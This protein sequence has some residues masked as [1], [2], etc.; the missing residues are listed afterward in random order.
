MVLNQTLKN[1]ALQAGGSHYP[2]V[3]T[4]QLLKFAQLLIEECHWQMIANGVDDL[5]QIR[6]Y[7]GVPAKT[8]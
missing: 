4:Q 2:D 3:N 6:E 5:D 7:F 8:G 1:I